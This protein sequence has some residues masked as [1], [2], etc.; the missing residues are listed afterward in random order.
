M[1]TIAE[2][3]HPKSQIRAVFQMI[4]PTAWVDP[5]DSIEAIDFP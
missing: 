2:R 4:A 5:I 3:P 1:F